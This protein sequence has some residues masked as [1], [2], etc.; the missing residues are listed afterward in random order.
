MASI[1]RTRDGRW[2]ARESVRTPRGPRSR[3]LASFRELDD[4]T[5]EHAI[6]RA[7]SPLTAGELIATARRAGAPVAM[8]PADQAAVRLL[9]ELTRS[10]RPRVGLRRALAEHLAGEESPSHEIRAGAEWAGVGSDERAKTL[11]DLLE[12]VDAMP[13]KRRGALR[14]PPL[15]SRNE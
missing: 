12:L 4:E 1:V 13:H 9:H 2:E 6:S 7:G 14:F 10:R 5:I 8:N 15:A 3:T 11:V